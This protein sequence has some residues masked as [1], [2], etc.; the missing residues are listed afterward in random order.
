MSKTTQDQYLYHCGRDDIRTKLNIEQEIDYVFQLV[1]NSKTLFHQEKILKITGGISFFVFLTDQHNIYYS[2]PQTIEQLKSFDNL[3]QDVNE[4]IIDIAC[5]SQEILALSNYGNVYNLLK[6]EKQIKFTNNSLI[7]YIA[8]GDGSSFAISIEDKVYIWG[9]NTSYRLGYYKEIEVEST[10]NDNN[11]VMV[12][13][14]DF[15][16]DINEPIELTTF[17]PPL[18][19][20][21]K[22]IEITTDTTFSFF[23]TSLGYIYSCGEEDS[24]VMG[25][26]KASIKLPTRIKSLEDKFI[27]S[28]KTGSNTALILTRDHELF[29][30]GKNYLEDNH[31]GSYI[32][33]N[34]TNNVNK[35]LK[36]MND[37]IE[38]INC[39]N[40]HYT[41]LSKNGK[42]LQIGSNDNQ[43]LGIG[44]NKELINEGR[45]IVMDITPP[46]N[47]RFKWS[48][49]GNYNSTL[50]LADKESKDLDLFFIKLKERV[51]NIFEMKNSN[52]SDINISFH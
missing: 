23:I 45:E 7:K 30:L 14:E 34:I 28:V 35:G 37:Y 42:I 31:N 41:F 33:I 5:F 43:Q 47:I 40:E 51:D 32:P 4:K 46:E 21:E 27:K 6:S 8:Q 44:E 1:Q 24:L 11:I 26:D 9:N 50:L 10:D 36:I 18:Q 25:H 29:V 13:Q 38:V 17:D 19:Q 3:K 15:I 20:D 22:V 49:Y 52:I 12:K 39:G 48:I 2:K 16:S